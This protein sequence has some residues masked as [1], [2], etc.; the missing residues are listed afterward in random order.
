[1]P[2]KNGLEKES[3]RWNN[4]QKERKYEEQ[5]FEKSLWKKIWQKKHLEEKGSDFWVRIF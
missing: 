1:M 3:P 2:T 5:A 4:K